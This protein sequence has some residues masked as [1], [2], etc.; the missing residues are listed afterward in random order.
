MA[1][2]NINVFTCLSIYTN[3][4]SPY[5]HKHQKIPLNTHTLKIPLPSKNCCMQRKRFHLSNTFAKQLKGEVSKPGCN[6]TSIENL[7]QQI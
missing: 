2:R 4:S 1:P 5:T 6:K 7:F 3:P